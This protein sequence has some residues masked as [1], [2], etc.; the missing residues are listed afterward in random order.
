LNLPVAEQ[1]QEEITPLSIPT[2]IGSKTESKKN[3]VEDEDFEDGLGDINKS[4]ISHFLTKEERKTLSAE[5]RAAWRA[6][7][8]DMTSKRKGKL[9]LVTKFTVI[10]EFN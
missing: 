8:Q 10:I 2:R 3:Y 1:H 6:L 7:Q 4:S 9:I 5:Q